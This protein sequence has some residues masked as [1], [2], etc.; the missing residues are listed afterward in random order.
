MTSGHGG[1]PGSVVAFIRDRA[2]AWRQGT[3][4]GQWY[5]LTILGAIS[6]LAFAVSFLTP[7]TLPVSVFAIPVVLGGLTLRNRPLAWLVAIDVAL[8]VISLTLTSRHT[9]WI[10]QQAVNFAVL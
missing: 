8:V 10:F 7:I 2:D 5:A 4:Q 3:R 1:A 6:V 9:S